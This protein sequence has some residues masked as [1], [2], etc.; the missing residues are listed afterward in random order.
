MRTLPENCPKT[1][2]NYLLFKVTVTIMNIII[3][4]LF[5]S[6]LLFFFTLT[7]FANLI[8]LHFTMIIPSMI[9][10]DK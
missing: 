10:C 9:I 6:F 3:Y 1:I 2:F 7:L 5:H 8:S 4:Y